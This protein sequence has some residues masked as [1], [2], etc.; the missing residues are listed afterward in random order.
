MTLANPLA[1]PAGWPR[2]PE[3]DRR[4]GKYKFR[5]PSSKSTGKRPSPF[6]TFPEARDR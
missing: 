6:W 3:T 4:E 2:T 5:R 1:W